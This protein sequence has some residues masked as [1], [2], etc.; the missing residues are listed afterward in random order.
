MALTWSVAIENY[1]NYIRFEK[2]L[3]EHTVNNYRRDLDQAVSFFTVDSPAELSDYAVRDWLH[4]MR[5]KGVA[6]KTIQ[7]KLSALRNFFRYHVDR[8]LLQDNP[9]IAVKPP[10]SESTLPKVLDVDEINQ[11][12]DSP[13]ETWHEMR[14]LCMLELFYSSGLRLAELAALDINDID[15]SQSLVKVSGKGGKERIVPVGAKANDK[16]QAWLGHR[17]QYAKPANSALFISALGQRL[18]HRSIQMRLARLG[19]KSGASRRMHPHLMRHSFASHMLQSSSDIRAVQDLLGHS[20]ISSTQIYT[21]LDFQYL[22]K[23][24]DQAHPRAKSPKD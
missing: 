5:R 21:H 19:V 13:A 20:D 7:R 6:R 3:A 24:Y 12:L 23:A 9:V 22:A 8:Q 2:Q 4:A 11:L 16:L 17:E 1:L 18:S 14:D 15:F 10:K